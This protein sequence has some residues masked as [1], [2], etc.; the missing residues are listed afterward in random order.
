MP[1]RNKIHSRHLLH[2]PVV[3]VGVKVKRLRQIERVSI[4]IVRFLL[5]CASSSRNRASQIQAM[6]TYL[7]SRIHVPNRSTLGTVTYNGRETEEI[8]LQDREG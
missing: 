2:S 3:N 6:V 5:L 7:L 8:M 4:R 1:H